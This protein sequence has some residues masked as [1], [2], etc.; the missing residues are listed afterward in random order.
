MSPPTNLPLP[1]DAND[2]V[3][4]LV[5]GGHKDGVTTDAVHEDAGARFN[6]VKVHVA[7]LGDQ[8]NHV[9]LLAN[10][11]FRIVFSRICELNVTPI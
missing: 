4:C 9:V 3:S 8:V 11:W 10:L 1:V 6:V 5:R 7:I 2:A